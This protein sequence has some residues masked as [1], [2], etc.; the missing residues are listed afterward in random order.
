MRTV[1]IAPYRRARRTGAAGDSRGACGRRPQHVQPCAMPC[2][3]CRGAGQRWARLVSDTIERTI[4][5]PTSPGVPAIYWR[6]GK[7]PLSARSRR[8]WP[9]RSKFDAYQLAK[10]D[11]E[12]V[13]RLR[14][15]LFLSHAK[16]AN[17][18]QC[19]CR[20]GSPTTN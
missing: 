3:W 12:N 4:R 8:A 6:N 18:D 13:V 14:D 19:I 11:R 15:V 17:D 1:S 5:V 2:C 20:S 9:R 10:Y 7:T 16:P